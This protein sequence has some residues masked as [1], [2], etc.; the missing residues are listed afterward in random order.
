MSGDS[1][2]GK[3]SIHGALALLIGALVALQLTGAEPGLLYLAPAI[4]L[5]GALAF[6]C[7]PGERLLEAVA[8]AWHPARRSERSAS[9]RLLAPPRSSPRGGVLLA[10]AL[11]GRGPPP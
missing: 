2:W 11:A 9:P 10:M 5:L 3:V 4:L 6:G 7:Y 1:L 8:R